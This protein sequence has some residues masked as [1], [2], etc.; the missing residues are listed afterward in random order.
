MPN[1]KDEFTAL[2]GR[3]G[4]LP[5][6]TTA[7]MAALLGKNAAPLDL[8][9]AEADFYAKSDLIA[10]QKAQTF[11]RREASALTIL[12]TQTLYV[13]PIWLSAGTKISSISFA[14]GA[15]TVTP[16]HWLVGLFNSSRVLLASSTDDTSTVWAINTIRSTS[17]TTAYVTTYT[18]WHYVGLAVDASTLPTVANR[19]TV[20]LSLALGGT[21]GDALRGVPLGGL[22]QA[23]I[24]TALPSTFTAPT[25]VGIVPWA[26]VA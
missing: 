14:N 11:E 18:G 19:P 24:T 7:T 20:T 4:I 1:V 13:S 2:A 5:G 3:Y 8:E 16:A 26:S 25:A 17:L 21:A 23:S 10:G 22:C 15:A 12:V 6:R 9:L